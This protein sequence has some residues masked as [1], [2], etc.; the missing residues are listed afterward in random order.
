[1]ISFCFLCLQAIM[2]ENRQAILNRLARLRCCRQVVLDNIAR[3]ESHSQSVNR[4]W[5]QWSA[6]N[7][8]SA[9]MGDDFEDFMRFY[10]PYFDSVRMES[11]AAPSQTDREQHTTASAT[12]NAI[13]VAQQR[14][15]NREQMRAARASMDT[16]TE[17][18]TVNAI[19]SSSA[20]RQRQ[21]T[22]Q[23]S[24]SHHGCK[25]SRSAERQGQTQ[26]QGCQSQHGCNCSRSAEWQGQAQIQ[27]C[28]S[29]HGCNC[30]SSAQGTVQN[31]SQGCKSQLTANSTRWTQSKGQ[32][33]EE[34]KKV[35]NHQCGSSGKSKEKTNEKRLGNW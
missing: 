11:T 4:Q 2:A 21:T 26:I 25:C 20:E 28:Q 12:I 7:Q 23:G 14:G 8:Q 27:G 16:T 31:Q 30:S 22:I 9:P 19:C 3:L 18:P 15:R 33:K 29:H 5:R 10:Q 34:S 17:V 32:I 35:S 6:Q 24:Q 1:M 13:A